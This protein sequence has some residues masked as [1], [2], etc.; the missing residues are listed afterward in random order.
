V[1]ITYHSIKAHISFQFSAGI[2]LFEMFYRPLE[3]GMERLKTLTDMRNGPHFPSDFGI[4]LSEAARETAKKVIS[5]TFTAEAVNPT[6]A[7]EIFLSKTVPMVEMR[8]TEFQM[9][10]TKAISDERSRL[11]RWMMDSLFNRLP[12]STLDYC[13]D[14][15]I[16]KVRLQE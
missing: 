10:F 12:S 15:D 6:T 9:A 1:P 4:S 13:F 3:A 2:V 5:W 8:E 7:E 14:Q 16:Y 11:F